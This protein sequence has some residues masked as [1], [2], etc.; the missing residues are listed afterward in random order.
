MFQSK[1][2]KINSMLDERFNYLFMM[3]VNSV[4][5]MND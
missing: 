5:E 3:I 1:Y 4:S 2:K